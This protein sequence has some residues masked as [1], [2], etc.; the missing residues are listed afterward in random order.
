MS[1]QIT[2]EGSGPVLPTEP[3]A[4]AVTEAKKPMGEVLEEPAGAACDE[5]IRAY[6]DLRRLFDEGDC[7]TV[8]GLAMSVIVLAEM[9]GMLLE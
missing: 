2:P 1:G 3:A 5:L 6:D 7:S 9:V 4:I 8:P